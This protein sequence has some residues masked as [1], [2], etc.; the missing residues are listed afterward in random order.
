M[1]TPEMFLADV[2][3]SQPPAV[4]R[5][6]IHRF[7]SENGNSFEDIYRDVTNEPYLSQYKPENA[8]NTPQFRKRYFPPA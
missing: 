8:P 3:R 1:M 5:N 2:A 6:V 4:A 7:L